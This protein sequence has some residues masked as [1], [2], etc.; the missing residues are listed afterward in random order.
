MFNR[1]TKLDRILTQCIRLIV[2]KGWTI[3]ECLDRY[4]RDSIELEPM[5]RTALRLHQARTFRPSVEIRNNA[6]TRFRSRLNT[7]RRSPRLSKSMYAA[8]QRGVL[9]SLS[10]LL[11]NLDS[12]QWAAP[13][14]LIMMV[15]I[16]TGGGVAYAA[17]HAKPGD[18]LYQVD[19]AIEKFRINFE[20][21]K[22]E[23]VRLHLMFAEERLEEAFAV[24]Q[25][26]DI[27][28]LKPAL[29]GYKVQIIATAHLITEA[30]TA[31]EDVI[32]LINEGNEAITAHEKKLED[33]IKIAPVEVEV[34]IRNII[35]DAEEIRIVVFS[36]LPYKPIL[37]LTPLPL[38]VLATMANGLSAS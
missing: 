6:Q 7:S 31:G 11:Q 38:V 5:L 22:Q 19:R 34:E 20:N 3:E 23:V 25:D 26:G 4:S 14:L 36:P 18:A 28:G 2:G 33:L 12:L 17:D 27:T 15:L 13:L 29:D 32:P 37:K 21:D 30:Y 9:E 16:S 24:M 35:K 10:S 8:P 1:S